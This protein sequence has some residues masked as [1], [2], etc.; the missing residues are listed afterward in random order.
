[1]PS[2]RA[3]SQPKDWTQVSCISSTGRL[4]P[5]ALEKAMAAHSSTL[6]WKIPWTEEPGRLQSMGSLRVRHNWTTS[7]SLSAFMHWRRQWQPTPVFLPGESQGWGA[8][9][10]AVFG[11]AQSRTQLKR[12]SSSRN[13]RDFWVLILY[14]A[15]LLYSLISSSNFLV[16]SLVLHVEDH[17]I[18]KQWEF[19][20]SSN[21]D[22]FYFF[23]CSDCCGQNFQNYVE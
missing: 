12:L 22:S 9:W 17:V 19:Y 5:Y 8:W 18:C 2:S 14:P 11:V 10:A 21:L 4:I 20:F 13:A 1:M 16:E 15:T 7:L 3:S 6:A 23:F